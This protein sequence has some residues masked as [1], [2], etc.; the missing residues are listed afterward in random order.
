MPRVSNSRLRIVA[1]IDLTPMASP[2]RDELLVEHRRD[3]S[4]RN[5]PPIGTSE[6]A[7]PKPRSSKLTLLN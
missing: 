6:R 3:A 1:I 5:A 4:R 2:S 7:R